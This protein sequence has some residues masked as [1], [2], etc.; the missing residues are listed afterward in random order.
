MNLNDVKSVITDV[1]NNKNT[2]L[3]SLYPII[4]D[5][6]NHDLIR[7]AD[8]SQEAGEELKD[9]TLEY[10]ESKFISNNS[11]YYSPITEADDR[12]NAAYSYD[13]QNKPI[14]LNVLDIVL[15]TPDQI[16]FSFNKDEFDNITGF[17][18]RLDNGL[19]R[20][21]MYKHHHHLSTM[22]ADST[23][24]IIKSDHRFVKMNE[25]VI[26]LSG[27]VDVIQIQESLIVT[28]LQALEKTFGYE[29]A[30][31]TQAA[32]NIQLI[33]GLGLLE[34]ITQLTE[35]AEHLG[36]AKKI[37]QF[38]ADSPVLTLP[39]ASVIGFVTSHPPIMRKFRISANGKIDLHTQVSRSL[40]LKLIND[41]LLTSE[42]TKIY[43][44]GLAKD[45]M[46][47]DEGEA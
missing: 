1:V 3:L 29:D 46:K 10:L 24:G 38:K 32:I 33:D 23:F 28:D 18:I 39:L 22:K 21:A 42:L 25:D 8:I 7:F 37:M 47:V 19:T 26:K 30:I 34:D 43:Y 27:K 16:Q 31:R 35:M 17:V 13:L 6:N 44:S 41:D 45:K 36:T 15:N 4:E 11:L 40:F 2:Y 14:G 12:K 9:L 5:D 20:I